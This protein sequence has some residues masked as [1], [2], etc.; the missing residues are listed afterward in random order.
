MAIR[1]ARLERGRV[2]LVAQEL[3]DLGRLDPGDRLLLRDHAL[4]DHVDRDLARRPRRSAW[5]DRVW[6]M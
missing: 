1:L 3:V 4:V 5:R 2:E 6:S